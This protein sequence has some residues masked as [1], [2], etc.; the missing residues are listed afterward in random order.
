[1]QKLE[2]QKTDEVREQEGFNCEH[3]V[4]NEIKDQDRQPIDPTVPTL[5][6][7]EE[8]TI[9]ISFPSYLGQMSENGETSKNE[10]LIWNHHKIH[11]NKSIIT[12]AMPKL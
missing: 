3:L 11:F 9:P 7:I 1:M 10:L 5:N 4:H 6:E 12:S 2:R 8:T